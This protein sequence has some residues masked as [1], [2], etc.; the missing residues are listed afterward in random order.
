MKHECFDCDKPATYQLITQFAG[1]H[2]YCAKHAKANSEFD[3]M[4]AFPGRRPAPPPPPAPPA[5]QKLR[6]DAIQGTE[7]IHT[8]LGF[9]AVPTHEELLQEVWYLRRRVKELERQNLNYSWQLHPESMG[10]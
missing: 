5:L 6:Q 3:D 1:T 2:L 10:R 4:V 9:D 7:S 8:K